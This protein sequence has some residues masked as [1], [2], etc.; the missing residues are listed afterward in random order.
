MNERVKNRILP[1]SPPDQAEGRLRLARIR[2]ENFPGSGG[3][4]AGRGV[5]DLRTNSTYT[6]LVWLAVTLF[7]LISG[8]Y[9]VAAPELYFIDAHSQ[10]DHNVRD[11]E[12][13]IQRMNEAGV[14]RTILAARSG[15]KP[16]EVAAFA[17]EHRERI[18]PAVRTKSGA[19]N[20]NRPQYY[21]ELRRQIDSGRFQAM[22]EILLYHA[23]K[24]DKAPEVVVYP[25][26]KRVQFALEEA[27]DKG[28]PFVIHI[29]FQSLGR[30]ERQ[31]FMAS[32]EALLAA[33]PGHP[34]VLNHMGQLGAAEVRRLIEDHRN[35]HFLTAH[36][37]PFI[38]S[39]SNEPW[40]NMFANTVL[41]PEWKGLVV[42]HPDRF[43]F[44]LDN[45]WE[46]HWREY[47]PAQMKYWKNAMAD[48]P[49]DAA[50]AVAHGNAERLW[51]IPPKTT[52]KNGIDK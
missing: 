49:P 47:Y 46:M 7:L 20:K 8:K 24:G 52:M 48:L 11:L 32:M 9:S 50:H 16:E 42:Q 22:A 12:L 38:I 23:Q 14:Y 43:I 33:H 30:K 45:V 39:H 29:E 25:D 34:V 44:A 2:S 18:V 15:R 26:D 19:Y 41:A 51:N 1:Q 21:K 5:A 35:I 36:T 4:P 40:V 6:R 13:I 27:I 10:V 3:C 31:R 37:N 17:E 28:W